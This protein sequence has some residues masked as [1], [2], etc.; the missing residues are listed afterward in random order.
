MFNF[1]IFLLLFN[2]LDLN[3]QKILW[4]QSIFQFER[5][6]HNLN[7]PKAP[8]NKNSKSKLLTKDDLKNKA[9]NS[10][11]E[12]HCATMQLSKCQLPVA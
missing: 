11:F 4:L 7:H 3:I 8:L 9:E 10:D 5:T 2:A 1:L 6:V 12:V